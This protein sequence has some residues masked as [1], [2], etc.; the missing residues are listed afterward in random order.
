M[1]RYPTA[2]DRR[3]LGVPDK[4]QQRIRASESATSNN[5]RL[6]LQIAANYGGRWDYHP[7]PGASPGRA[8]W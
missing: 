3:H 8:S 1:K 4:L 6:V 2:R 5:R 7:G